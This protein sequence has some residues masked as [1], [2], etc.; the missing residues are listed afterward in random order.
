[1]LELRPNCEYC[2]KDLH[3]ESLEAR[4]CSDGGTFCAV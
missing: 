2:Y 4:I 1:M 3:S